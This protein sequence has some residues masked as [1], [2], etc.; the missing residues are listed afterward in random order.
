MLLLIEDNRR[1]KRLAFR[2]L[3]GARNRHRLSVLRNGAFVRIDHLAI[4]LTGGVN[5]IVIDPLER[6]LIKRRG[7]CRF[8]GFTI[9]RS[10]IG[11]VAR[12]TLVIGGLNRCFEAVA[13]GFNVNC[14]GLIAGFRTHK[15]RLNI[16]WNHGRAN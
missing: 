2:I 1:V 14:P 15:R 12:L 11:E 8:A 6:D 16:F 13:I 7:P 4:L 10:L 9:E 5:R 3:T